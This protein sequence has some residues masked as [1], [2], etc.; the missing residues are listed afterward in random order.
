ML[1]RTLRQH[2][3]YKLAQHLRVSQVPSRGSWFLKPVLGEQRRLHSPC[4]ENVPTLFCCSCNLAAGGRCRTQT[5]VQLDLACEVELG[6]EL[7]VNTRVPAS[8]WSNSSSQLPLLSVCLCFSIPL[9]FLIEC[10]LLLSGTAQQEGGGSC[11]EKQF[12]SQEA[13]RVLSP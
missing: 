13:T 4:Q 1:A 7:L 2:K 11:Q 3:S 8:V 6:V 12:R 10:P 9:S 5:V